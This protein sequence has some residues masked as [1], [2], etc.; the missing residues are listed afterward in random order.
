[1]WWNKWLRFL[2]NHHPKNTS[3]LITLG[4]I[5][6]GLGR[7]EE[8]QEI[9]QTVLELDP[10]QEKLATAVNQLQKPEIKLIIDNLKSTLTFSSDHLG[11]YFNKIDEEEKKGET[12]IRSI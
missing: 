8:A 3:A 11:V 5:F 6:K 4:Q 10:I 1:M 9:Y 7:N 12:I 2:K